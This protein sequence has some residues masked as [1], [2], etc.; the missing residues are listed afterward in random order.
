MISRI[1]HPIGQGAFYTE[2][3]SQIKSKGCIPLNVTDDLDNG[4]IQI[5]NLF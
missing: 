5:I 1:L 4:A 2:L 3:I